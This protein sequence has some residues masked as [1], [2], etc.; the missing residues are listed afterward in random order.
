MQRFSTTR[1][2]VASPVW[3]MLLLA[4]AVHLPAQA[5]DLTRAAWL[6]GPNQTVT[7]Q[8]PPDSFGVY[9]W[10][11]LFT[12]NYSDNGKKCY[13]GDLSHTWS[14]GISADPPGVRVKYTKSFWMLPGQRQK[15]VG[16]DVFFKATPVSGKLTIHVPKGMCG[17]S[18]QSISIMVKVVK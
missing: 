6:N 14:D 17:G 13:L 15:E 4:L 9:Q 2:V 7:L 18:D 10:W 8:V 16:I 12:I 3:T 11:Q 1:L 5:A